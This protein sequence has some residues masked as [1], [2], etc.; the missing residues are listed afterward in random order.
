MSGKVKQVAFNDTDEEG[1]DD[2]PIRAPI[3]L[4]LEVRYKKNE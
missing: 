3:Q 4:K 1:D 2:E